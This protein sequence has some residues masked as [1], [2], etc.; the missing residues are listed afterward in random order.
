MSMQLSL[1]FGEEPVAP[2]QDVARDVLL[3]GRRQWTVTYVRHRRARHYV[4]RVEDDGSLRV[5]I[6][7]G[8]SRKDAERFARHKA[9]WIDRERYRRAMAR[10]NPGGW[11]DGS[12]VLLRG[13]ALSLR[14]DA[15]SGVVWLGDDAVPLAAGGKETVHDLVTER[16]RRLAERELPSRLSELAAS[17]GHHVSRITVRDQRSRWGSCSPA[18]RISLNWRL[19]QVPPSVRDYVL[20]HELTHLVESNHSS[21]FWKTLEEVCP[22]HREARQW[23]RTR[24]SGTMSDPWSPHA[25]TE[26]VGSDRRARL[27]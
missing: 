19:I 18:G 10:A 17:H 6:P 16:L 15:Q 13:E 7:R 14:F 11:R 8:G 26:P 27:A 22:W 21:R 3:F 23:L 12:V 20:L 1:S 24:F 25:P 2:P 9:D 4:L 5:T